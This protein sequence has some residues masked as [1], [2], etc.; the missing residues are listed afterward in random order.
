MRSR[1]TLILLLASVVLFLA[2][3]FYQWEWPPLLHDL[4]DEKATVLPFTKEAQ[5]NGFQEKSPLNSTFDPS[6]NLDKL[7]KDH[8]FDDF[9]LS[10]SS[11]QAMSDFLNSL[12]TKGMKLRSSMP[13]ILTARLQILDIDLGF[14]ALREYEGVHGIEINSPIF[15]PRKPMVSETDLQA[16]EPKTIDQWINIKEDRSDWGKGTSIAIIDSAI[17]FSHPSLAHVE[18]EVIS[19][20]D[21]PSKKVNTNHGTAIASIIAGSTDAF[22]GI[23]PA[24]KILSI[25]LLGE[26]GIG[27]VFTLSEAIIAAVERKVDLI[28]L[29]LGGDRPSAALSHAIK[30]ATSNNVLLVAAS[31]N[32]GIPQVSYPARYDEVLG[33]SALNYN[34]TVANFSNFGEGVEL[35]AP[36][37]D[38]ISAYGANGYAV[39]NGT[40]SATA[41][42]SGAALSELS[43]NPHLS[44]QQVKELLFTYAD[45]TE[46]PGFDQLSGHGM[47]NLQRIIKRNDLE[48]HDGSLVGYYFT[49]EILAS[50][51][52]GGTVPFLVTV[53][54]KGSSWINNM[55]LDV[56][57]QG[58]SRNF[59]FSNMMPGQTRS[60]QLYLDSTAAKEGVE[61]F[62]KLKLAEQKDRNPANNYRKSILILPQ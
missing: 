14:A 6:S 58:I 4:G 7:L 62:S 46:K 51:E 10:F 60:E 49:P 3:L 5:G 59:M 40:S 16:G 44:S 43:R 42:V 28:N 26:D 53:Q 34:G 25:E 15:M 9:A 30:Y 8:R 33:V 39:L 52:G 41:F 47:L 31:G 19:F 1:L 32:D 35:S 57:Y 17:D 54:N 21:N 56:S 27:D 22:Q 20:I 48:Y 38:V 18:R 37:V 12:E 29:S 61:I 2:S 23:A 24:A 50:I 36:G 55:T 45:E 13:Q 11:P